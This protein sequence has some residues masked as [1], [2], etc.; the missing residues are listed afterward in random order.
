MKT[1]TRRAALAGLAFLTT[2]R[3]VSADPALE[4]AS[5]LIESL[6]ARA[7]GVLRRDDLGLEQRE[8]QFRA[9]LGEGF[10]LAFIGRFVL[11]KHWQAADDDQRE[12][13]QALFAEFVLRTYAARFGGYKGETFTVTGARRSG[14]KDVIVACAISRSGAAPIATEWRVRDVQGGPRIIDVAVE[15]ISMALNQRQEFDSVVA[16]HGLDGLI[17]MLRARVSKA[18][19]AS[20]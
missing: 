17:A 7:I 6:A 16:Q 4:P 10:D 13:Y 12:E 9:I 1:I 15:G 19:V 3:R 20:G 11:G 14:D 2:L 5:R 18:V 8:A